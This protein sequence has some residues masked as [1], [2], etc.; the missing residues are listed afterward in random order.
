MKSRNYL[1]SLTHL[2]DRRNWH[3]VILWKMIDMIVNDLIERNDNAL[4][5]EVFKEI[6]CYAKNCK[7]LTELEDFIDK[8]VY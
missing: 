6:Y 3:S 5:Y 8:F 4:S 7:S 2:L 1:I